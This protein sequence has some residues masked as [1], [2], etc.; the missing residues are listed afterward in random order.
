V[1]DARILNAQELGGPSPSA[2]VASGG[3]TPVAGARCLGRRARVTTRGVGPKLRLGRTQE[4]LTRAAGAPS[5]R[6]RLAL[7]YCVTGGGQ[8]VIAF[9]PRLDA[10]LIVAT[11]RGYRYRGVGPGRRLR[12]ARRKLGRL[13]RV[14]RGLYLA[15][16][17]RRI[18]VGVR[19]GRVRYVGAV[20]RP[21][22]RQRALIRVYVNRGGLR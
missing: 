22:A 6:A 20:A 1:W 12:L 18:V 16:R 17:S 14:G 9:S 7:S 5:R 2:G 11:A 19:R 4:A 15:G 13:T 8:V 3:G 10:R 21:L